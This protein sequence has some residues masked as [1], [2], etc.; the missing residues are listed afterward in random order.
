[1]YEVRRRSRTW[2]G[3]LQTAL[4]YIEALFE[5]F[6][7]RHLELDVYGDNVLPLPMSAEELR[8]VFMRASWCTRT[9]PALPWTMNCWK[10]RRP[11]LHWVKG[12]DRVGQNSDIYR[13]SANAYILQNRNSAS[14]GEVRQSAAAHRWCRERLIM[15]TFDTGERLSEPPP[16]F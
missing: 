10:R 9:Y 2:C 14:L 11:K 6:S 16:S 5:S 7:C 15:I 4:C 13:K 12:N 3:V 1:V 8:D